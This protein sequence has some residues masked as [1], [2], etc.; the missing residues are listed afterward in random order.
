MP[1]PSPPPQSLH[2]LR[3][4]LQQLQHGW[5]KHPQ[6]VWSLLNIKGSRCNIL[7]PPCILAS[8]KSGLVKMFVWLKSA[9]HQSRLSERIDFIQFG[10]S[11][12]DHFCE[13]RRNIVFNVGKR[14]QQKAWHCEQTSPRRSDNPQ[15]E[16]IL[17]KRESRVQ[18][19]GLPCKVPQAPP[20]QLAAHGKEE[21]LWQARQ[22][23]RKNP[24]F[25]HIGRVH[26]WVTLG[27]CL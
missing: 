8:R 27:R 21:Q 25:W 9:F 6:P 19:K 3:H 26:N 13:R 5:H 16:L 1:S 24:A 15:R 14:R 4:C 18:S 10:F 12:L 11:H 23:Q 17:L 20:L 2:F 7:S 22:W